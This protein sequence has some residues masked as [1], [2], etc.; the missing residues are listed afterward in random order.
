MSYLFSGFS[1]K[2]EEGF[3][4]FNGDISEWDVSKV[5]NMKSM[6]QNASA[7]NGDIS[8]WD[9]SKVTNMD[10]MFN[11][12]PADADFGFPQ[13]PNKFNGDISNWNVSNVINMIQMFEDSNF[14]QNLE[15]WGKHI[16]KDIDKSNMFTNSKVTKLPSWY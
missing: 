16:R 6:F 11:G 13:K 15:A 5:T 10:N 3:Y 2:T 8:K 14:A 4:L 1:F 12:I 7:F 9:V